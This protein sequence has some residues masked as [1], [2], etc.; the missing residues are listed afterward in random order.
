[1]EVIDMFSNIGNKIKTLAQT[2]CWVGI[3]LSVIV[4][5]ALVIT[6]EITDLIGFLVLI[7]GPIISWLS[8]FMTYGFGQLIENSDILVEQGYNRENTELDENSTSKS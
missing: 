5:I 7:C 2:L 1:M 3:I 4:G 8:S 6:D